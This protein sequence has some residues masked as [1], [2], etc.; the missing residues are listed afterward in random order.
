VVQ[1][2]SDAR[3]LGTQTGRASFSVLLFQDLAVIPIL[4]LVNVLGGKSDGLVF[5]EIAL[6]IIQAVLAMIVIVL[7]GRYLLR[8]LLRLVAQTRSPDLFMAA[9]L[10]IAVGTGVAATVAG[11]SMAMGAFVAGLLLAETE[12]RRELHGDE[13]DVAEHLAILYHRNFAV[14]TVSLRYFT[15]VG[16]RQRPDMGM[17]R[18]IHTLEV[19]GTDDAARLLDEI[20]F[21]TVVIVLQDG[22]VIQIETSEKIRLR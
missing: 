10:F 2:L 1:L 17:H 12:F 20:A 9:T 7:I 6:A 4:L 14:P 3:R 16:P 22:K 21:G 18:F 15:V 13:V 8:P 5:S 19:F 11:L